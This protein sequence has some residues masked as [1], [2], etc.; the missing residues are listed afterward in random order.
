MKKYTH[1]AKF[2]SVPCVNVLGAGAQVL[3]VRGCRVPP[4]RSG[5]GC[6]MVDTAGSSWL[7]QTHHR[8]QL[9]CSATLVAPQG[10][11]I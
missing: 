4:V 1:Q 3:A 10:N 2:I 7:K 11:Q 6:P 5:W 9:S 8:A